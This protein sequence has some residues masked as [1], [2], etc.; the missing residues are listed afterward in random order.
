MMVLG[1]DSRISSTL[2]VES[3][4]RRQYTARILSAHRSKR[5]PV[6]EAL[7]VYSQTLITE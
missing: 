3:H 7:F 2:R 1:N 5:L 4:T 6:R